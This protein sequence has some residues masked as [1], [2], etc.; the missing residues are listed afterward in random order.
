MPDADRWLWN[1]TSWQPKPPVGGPNPFIIAALVVI[2]LLIVA[3]L[4]VAALV[5]GGV[6][7][8]APPTVTR[9]SAAVAPCKDPVAQPGVA[10]VAGGEACG[11]KLG[12]PA[13]AL[14]CTTIPA[15][16]EVGGNSYAT[17]ISDG[18]QVQD[19]SVTATGSACA[20]S[21]KKGQ[22]LTLEASQSSPDDY[23]LIADFVPTATSTATSSR[24]GFTLRCDT[25]ICLSLE[26]QT[27][28]FYEMDEQGGSQD[29]ILLQ[30]QFAGQGG[31]APTLRID[32]PNRVLIEVRGSRVVAYLNGRGIGSVK[33]TVT[34]SVPAGVWL[35]N[36]YSTTDATLRLLSM[37]VWG[38][39]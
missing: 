15:G 31:A 30:G 35:A 16:G 39:G 23:V 3:G 10:P 9:N 24:F 33:T 11:V 6:L 18:Q 32:Q 36:D 5:V 22:G 13:Y 25:V 20:F 14:D 28:G 17:R 2:P 19:G 29:H 27:D 21:A 7:Q 8:V 12:A 37:K 38:T 26:L 1:G 34:G 4:A